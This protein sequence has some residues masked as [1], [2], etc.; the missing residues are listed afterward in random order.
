M[1]KL[2]AVAPIIVT[3]VWLEEDTETHRNKQDT[4]MGHHCLLSGRARFKIQDSLIMHVTG[5]RAQG[6]RVLYLELQ[7]G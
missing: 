7:R 2:T 1:L 6:Q 3:A 5:A 4:T